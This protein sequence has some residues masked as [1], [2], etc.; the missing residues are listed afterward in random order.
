MKDGDDQNGE[1]PCADDG[2]E[3]ETGDLHTSVVEGADV[4]QEVGYLY[5]ENS[6]DVD[7]FECEE[8]LDIVSRGLCLPMPGAPTFMKV[9][10][11]SG[12]NL[13]ALTPSP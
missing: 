13:E 10:R 4:H 2:A 1:R 8:C 11:T 7:A 12:A 5:Q 9:T 3:D 6:N